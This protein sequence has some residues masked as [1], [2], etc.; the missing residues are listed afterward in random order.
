M[1]RIF[2]AIS[3]S[4]IAMLSSSCGCCTSDVAAPPLRNM[5]QFREIPT[6]PDHVQ[7]EYSK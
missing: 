5:P 7:V 3:A 6:T 2:L 1:I 4:V